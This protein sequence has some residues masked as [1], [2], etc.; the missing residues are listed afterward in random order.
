VEF[1]DALPRDP[2]GKVRKRQIRDAL[3]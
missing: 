1:V 3:A 2:M